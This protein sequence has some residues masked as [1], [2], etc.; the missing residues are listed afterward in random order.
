MTDAAVIRLIS[1]VGVDSELALL[2]HFLDHYARLG[3]PPRHMHVILNAPDAASPALEEA[4]ARLDAHG[5]T[6]AELWI[7][8]YTSESM[9]AKRREVQA[10]VA[11]PGDWIVNADVDEFHEYPVPLPEFLAF[12]TRCGATMVQ[13]PFIDR[14]APQGRLAPVEAGRPLFEQFPI[15]ADV[16]CAL[17]GTGRHHDLH[18][19]VK[20]MAHRGSVFPSRGGHHPLPGQPAVPVYGLPL[21]RFPGIGTPAVRFTLPTKVHHFKW[22][23]RLCPG[24]ERR[25]A[26]TGVSPAGAEYGRKLLDYFAANQGIRLSDVPVR[27]LATGERLPWRMRVEALRAWAALDWRLTR[28][29]RRLPQRPAAQGR[30][31]PAPVPADRGES[32]ALEG[33]RLRQLTQG[34]ADGVF[35]AHSYYDIPVIDDA[36]RLAAAHRMSFA[37]RWMTAADAVT[38]GV[39]DLEADG[40]RP[41]GESRAWS[42]QQGPMAQWVPG[43]RVLIW[44]DR[45]DG[46]FVA[47][48]HDLDGGTTRTLPRPVYALHGDGR[49]AFCLNM[50][51]L[52]AVRPGYGYV[53]GEGGRMEEGR[54]AGDGVWRMDLESGRAELILS[55]DRAAGFLLS[56]LPAAE[57]LRHAVERRLYWFNHIK[58]SPDGRRFTVKLRFRARDL[59]KGWNEGMGV[60]LTCGVDGRDL[61]LLAPAT[62]HVIWRDAET[63]YF[64]QRGRLRLYRDAAPEGQWVRNLAPDLVS[65]NVHIRHLPGAPDVFILDTPYRQQVDLLVLDDR[66]GAHRRVARFDGHEPPTGPFRCDLH[67]VPSPDGRRIIVTSLHDGGRQLHVLERDAPVA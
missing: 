36:G 46:T 30:P 50:A 62:S 47:R 20:L 59:K 13:G 57:R 53:G 6:P 32:P 23:D 35:H 27:R 34:S 55:L 38:V 65:S 3:I 63:L 22:T 29:R 31:A 45:E 64:W 40:F 42:W 16:I 60:S 61:R 15:Q 17:G 19:T 21:A 37:G 44:N 26:T 54:P 28:L 51:R 1:C 12:C 4:R 33:W 56:R 11:A 2:D 48:L 66:V 67:P 9:W 5:A 14:L 7:A 39:V 43:S 52:D 24:L 18:G 41:L 58:V 49:T 8:P 10:R 25:L